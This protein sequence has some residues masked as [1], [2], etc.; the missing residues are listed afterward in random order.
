MSERLRLAVL[1]VAAAL[2]AGCAL[3][4]HA[5]RPDDVAA[6]RAVVE[7]FR[8]SIVAKDKATFMKLFH[9]DN[10]ERITWQAVVD[11]AALA[12]IRK[13]RSEAI[14]ARYRPDVNFVAFIDGIVASKKR[15]E[16]TFRDIEIDTDGEVASVSFDYDYRE[17]GVV[18]NFGREKWLLVRTEG[19]WKIVSVV[20][21]I[22]FPPD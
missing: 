14:K 16:E 19:G 12:K 5:N 13:N 9:S 2:L 8:H 17:D 6:I 3:S 1:F 18:T 21:T 15:E 4:P 22:R 11:D 10:P 7:A 20:F